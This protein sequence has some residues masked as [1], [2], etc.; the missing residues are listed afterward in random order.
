M[1]TVVLLKDIKSQRFDNS[2]DVFLKDSD[3]PVDLKGIMMG[4]LTVGVGALESS[5]SAKFVSEL[6][7][8]ITGQPQDA[9]L[10]FIHYMKVTPSVVHIG[11]SRGLEAIRAEFEGYVGD[12][13]EEVLE[14]MR[15]V[16][17]ERAGSN[18]TLFPN[19]PHKRDHTRNGETLADFVA[20]PDA[21][22]AR[23]EEAHVAALRIYTT[24]AYRV[25]N[26][27]LR[28]LERVGPHP[29]PVT[30]AFLREAIGKLRAV[31]A[32]EDQQRMSNRGSESGM[33]VSKKP[34]T[35]LDLWRG[36]RDTEVTDTFMQHGGTECVI[37]DR[38]QNLVH[39]A[40]ATA[41]VLARE[42]CECPGIDS[43]GSHLCRRP[44]SSRW[45]CSTRP[46]RRRCCS[47]CAPTRSCS[48]A[49]PSSSCPPFRPRRKVL[50]Q[51]IMHFVIVQYLGAQDGVRAFVSVS[52]VLYP[53]LTFLKPTGKTM[54]IPFKGRMFNVIEVTPQFGG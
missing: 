42:S 16:L 13:A 37:R 32:Q 25:L 45:R 20:H 53:P 21:R 43:L 3:E 19:S 23:L 34:E 49:P 35:R 30:I 18:D 24:A 51:P 29:F 1:R 26:D 28:D 22:T 11:L 36:M 47:S 4:V 10:G 40:T 5:E 50:L 12:R 54:S 31:G 14:C 33:E 39:T 2:M 44:S 52:T 41:N 27:P 8:L 7:S 17:F 15:Y 48:V 6:R 46:R 9:A 38:I